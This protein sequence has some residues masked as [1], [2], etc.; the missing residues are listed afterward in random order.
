MGKL[1]SIAALGDDAATSLTKGTHVFVD[2]APRAD[3]N[4]LRA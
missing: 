2:A 4:L 1:C 3:A